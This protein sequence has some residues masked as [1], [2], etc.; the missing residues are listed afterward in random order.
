MVNKLQEEKMYT[1]LN[2]L[3]EAG[4]V[5][6]KTKTICTLCEN[7]PIECFKGG[8]IILELQGCRDYVSKFNK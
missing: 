4:L 7:N 1:S 8:S 6:G 3:I 2:D 5:L